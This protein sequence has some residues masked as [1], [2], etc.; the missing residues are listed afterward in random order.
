MKSWPVLTNYLVR[1]SDRSGHPKLET[2]LTE[3][4]QSFDENVGTIFMRNIYHYWSHL[5]EIISIR[6]ILGHA[7]VPEYVDDLKK[8]MYH[9]E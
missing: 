9:P 3:G 2:F 1:S 8:V 4:E 5:G 6:Q 7:N